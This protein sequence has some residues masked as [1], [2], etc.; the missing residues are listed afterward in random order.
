MCLFCHFVCCRTEFAKFVHVDDGKGFELAT[1]FT[2]AD[3][4]RNFEDY[5]Q[6]E[7]EM[8]E[9]IVS[10]I[11]SDPTSNHVFASGKRVLLSSYFAAV[12]CFCSELFLY[13]L[14]YYSYMCLVMYTV[15]Y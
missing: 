7:G 12:K 15:S 11:K 13:Y 4:V 14:V 2:G 9:F 10:S 1:T 3:I 8:M 6:L 5:G